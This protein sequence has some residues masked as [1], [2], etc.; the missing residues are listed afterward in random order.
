MQI[1]RH[2]VQ[3][4]AYDVLDFVLLASLAVIAI[5]SL[6]FQLPQTQESEWQ[7]NDD[8]LREQLL[9]RFFSFNEATI[10]I[11]VG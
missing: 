1:V 8:Q 10:W 11:T 3:V 2:C 4:F 7:G 5:Q 9:Q 6:V